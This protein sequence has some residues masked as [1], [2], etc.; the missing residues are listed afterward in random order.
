[1]VS[2]TSESDHVVESTTFVADIPSGALV[3]CTLPILWACPLHSHPTYHQV[4]LSHVLYPYCGRVHYIHIRH[5]I[6]CTCHM[7][8]THIVGVSTTFRSDIPSGALVTCT[9]PI[10]WACPLH[11]DP[12][13]HQVHLSHVLYPD[14]GRV[15]FG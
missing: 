10:L 13:Y 2:A 6:R 9:L 1:M 5:T 11:S 4:H 15:R 14:C 12:T 8:S 7:Y 3:T